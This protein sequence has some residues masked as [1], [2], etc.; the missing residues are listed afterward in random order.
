MKPHRGII[1]MKKLT[2]IMFIFFALLFN[3]N[4]IHGQETR[5]ELGDKYFGQFAYNKAIALYEGARKRGNNTWRI[6]AK[7]GDC[8]Y[9]TAKPETALQY[10]EAAIDKNENIND[11]YLLRYALS[12]QSAE[13][14]RDSIL[15]A[16]KVYFN[17]IGMADEIDIQDFLEQKDTEIENLSIN[18]KY[19][20][21]GSF[22]FNDTLFFSSSRENPSKKRRDN[23]R[24]Y[25]WNDQPYL[26]IYSAAIER[27]SDSLS[28]NQISSDS[29]GININTI[30]HEATVAITNDGKTLYFSGGTLK[31]KNKLKYNKRGTSNL[32]LQRASRINNKWIV[33]EADKKAM[34]FL[35]FKYFSVGNPALSPDN[36][37]L[38]FVTCAPFPEAQGQT[39][40][41]YVDIN[42]NG[43]YSEVK[44]VP[45]VNTSGRESF[46]FISRDSTLYF[47]SDGVFNDKLSLGLLDI[48]KVENI[49]K[50]IADEQDAKI[51]H[52][53]SPFN[54]ARD[55]FAFYLEH[56]DSYNKCEEF[57]YFS[58]NR[59]DPNAKGDDDIYRV[60]IKKTKTIQGVVID[61]NTKEPIANAKVDLIDSSGM[62]LN[63]LTV[64]QSGAYSFDVE[65]DQ[66]YRIIGSKERY[67]DDLKELT[68][69][70]D[71]N[72]YLE[73]KPYPCSF[74]INH[75]EFDLDSDEVRT[76]VQDI[77][78]PVLDVLF[79]NPGL[80]IRIESHTDSQ[81]NETY[82]LNL[83]ERRAQN[84]KAYLL[85]HGVN[86]DQIIS[87]KGFGEKC[88]LNS[89]EVIN[90][91]SPEMR[92]DL[93]EQNRRS[94]FI[95]EDC[96]EG[97]RGCD[98]EIDE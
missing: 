8:Y 92:T 34:E 95:I 10:Y 83:S 97:Y 53:K 66:Y 1:S 85:S 50:V 4:I 19:S 78:I 87:A 9:Y 98:E 31:S 49:D 70:E 80:K 21:F 89:D 82:N 11:S 55:D 47:S 35:D 28:F 48:Y 33:T 6:N 29:S 46:P 62:R 40:I 44:S 91:A 2:N 72:L 14:H 5:I 88:L 94:I 96:L 45:G 7:L 77:I 74:S 51:T 75:I 56:S 17:K 20:D 68:D 86:E 79:T 39:D 22:I 65:C 16:F 60:K 61:I 63:T 36:K 71:E 24:L 84:T 32:K 54:S 58:S 25:K 90:N 73:L 15:S 59:V 64:D 52:L 41:Y 93:H 18:T 30:A 81:G 67:Y 12:L 69:K 27:H 13:K 43:S 3:V 57:A 38:Y 26:D 42:D 37:R 23:K 76:E